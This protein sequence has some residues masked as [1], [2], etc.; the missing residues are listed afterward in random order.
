MFAL[1]YIMDVLYSTVRNWTTYARMLALLYIINVLY[2][3]VRNCTTFHNAP[4]ATAHARPHNPF[5]AVT[6]R[7]AGACTYS[8]LHGQILG[9]V[10][11][12]A[13]NLSQPSSNKGDRHWLQETLQGT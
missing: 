5:T 1:L 13:R 7:C 6:P 10:A 3:T 2:S 4:L 11:R 12:V 8:V 9:I